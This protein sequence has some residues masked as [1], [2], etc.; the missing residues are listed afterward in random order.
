MTLRDLQIPTEPIYWISLS[1]VAFRG[2][3]LPDEQKRKKI[4]YVLNRGHVEQGGA[5]VRSVS[6]EGDEWLLRW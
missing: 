6:R 3:L 2:Q 4:A 1:V 5:R